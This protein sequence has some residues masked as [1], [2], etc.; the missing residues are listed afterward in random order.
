MQAAPSGPTGAHSKDADLAVGQLEALAHG[1]ARAGS[2]PRSSA[3]GKRGHQHRLLGVGRAAHPAG[4][5]VPAALD[6]ALDGRGG[7]AEP[8][9]AATQQVVVLVG[10]REPGADV[11][12]PFGL[13][14]VRRE[15]RRRSKSASAEVL[16]PVVQRCGRRAERTGPVDGRG[17][18]DAAPLQDVDRLVAR[19]CG[20]RSPGRARDRP[21]TRAGGSRCCS[22]SGPSSTI[23]TL[24]PALVSSS[25]VMP[26][27]GAGADDGDVAH[28]AS[29]GTGRVGAASDL[30]A[31]EQAVADRDPADCSCRQ[32]CAGP[33]S[34]ARAQVRGSEK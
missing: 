18:A 7:D 4:A 3:V 24:R 25:A 20:R 32:R 5:E 9:G 1:S 33:G 12:A 6:V 2:R 23:T 19:S 10:R 13:L 31:A 29:A 8:R 16:S 34:R 11:Q 14:E 27:A 26:R 21:R 22:C 17:A 28:A 15:L 30:P